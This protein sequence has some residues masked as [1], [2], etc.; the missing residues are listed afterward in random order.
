LDAENLPALDI[1]AEDFRIGNKELGRLELEAEPRERIWQLERLAISNPDGRLDAKGKWV[2][3]EQSSTEL[4]LSVQA[5]NIGKLLL[6]LGYPEGIKGGSGL[7]VGPV[8]WAG[9]P[10]RPDLASIAGQL[11]LEAAK[12]RFAKLEPGV[13]KLLGILSLQA[14]PRRLS[15]DF[16]D[17]FSS[18]FS[19]DRISAD[20]E[21]SRGVARTDNFRMDGS[22]AR[23]AMHGTVDLAMETQ[24]L[25]VKI[26]PQLSTGVAIAGAVISPAVGIATLLAQKALG[27]PVEQLA[28]TEYHVTGDWAAPRIESMLEKADTSSARR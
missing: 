3:G 15:L 11:Q 16:R 24:D 20:V 4:N 13:G 18:G 25:R 1:V 21:L 14:L 28:A 19:F 8:T 12:G 7:L 9:P 10:Y 17:V 23:V 2:L 22:A 6:R 5:T 27:D 26:F